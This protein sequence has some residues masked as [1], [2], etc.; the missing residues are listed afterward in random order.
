MVD[1]E[2]LDLGPLSRHARTATFAPNW[3][4]VLAADASV[5]LIIAA[6]GVAIVLYVGW[7]GWPLVVIG[8][9]YIFLVVR[10][11]LQWRWIRRK[12]GLPT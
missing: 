1:L 3:R 5:G 7:Y 4:A 11:Y 12:A 2:A 8:A 9:I 10:R 6:I